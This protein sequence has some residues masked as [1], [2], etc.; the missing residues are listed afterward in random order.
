MKPEDTQKRES[1]WSTHKRKGTYATHASGVATRS[2]ASHAGVKTPRTRR[3]T[4]KSDAIA[5]LKSASW[6]APRCHATPRPRATS[7]TAVI[8]YS[9]IISTKR[10]QYGSHAPT[11]SSCAATDASGGAE[12]LAQPKKATADAV[13]RSAAHSAPSFSAR[14]RLSTPAEPRHRKKATP[15][16]QSAHVKVVT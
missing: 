12:Q 9:G 4:R 6:R 3:G 11:Q 15:S 10:S 1:R 2:V 7:T 8:A 14:R 5:R 13:T 16:P